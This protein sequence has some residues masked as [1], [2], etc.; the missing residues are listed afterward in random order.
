MANT[1][2]I[3]KD[4]PIKINNTAIPFS[5]S[6]NEKYDTIE[7]VNVSEAGTDIVQTQR[8]AKLTLAISYKI[9]SSWIS[10]FETWYEDNTYKTVSIFNLGTGAY[11]DRLMRMRNYKKKLV[12]H[13]EDLA[14]TTGI[15]EVSFDLIEK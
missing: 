3:L 9:L 10:Q 7:N 11:K 4:Y 14:A 2:P 5:G 6:M 13:S 1:I 15:W 8:N 12:K